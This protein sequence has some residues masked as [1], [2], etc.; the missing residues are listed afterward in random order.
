[1]QPA[2]VAFVHPRAPD[3]VIVPEAS[4]RLMEIRARRSRL[5]RSS[6][7]QKDS[8]GPQRLV[9]GCPIQVSH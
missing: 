8:G 2:K 6:T 5:R 9:I 1:M 3:A 7:S 4:R